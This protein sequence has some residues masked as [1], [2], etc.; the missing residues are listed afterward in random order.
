TAAPAVDLHTSIVVG[1]SGGGV[2]H[3]D[4]GDDVAVDVVGVDV[5]QGDGNLAVVAGLDR[6]DVLGRSLGGL[7]APLIGVRKGRANGRL[8][9]LGDGG[10]AGR[11]RQ[12]GL[13]H[14]GALGV[15]GVGRQRDGV[16]DGDDRDDYHQF[17][18]RKYLL[19]LH[20]YF[21]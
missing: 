15:V 14:L 7:A 20:I 9:D 13:G 2:G 5:G 19:L 21:P 12:D 11:S 18:Q 1:Q 10:T 4:Q 8:H 3:R 6:L 16:K 17:D